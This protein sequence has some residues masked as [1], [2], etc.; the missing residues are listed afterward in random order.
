MTAQEKVNQI[1]A[2]HPELTS[3]A[4]KI[5]KEILARREKNND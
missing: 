3:D 1:L 2:E 4:I 5:L